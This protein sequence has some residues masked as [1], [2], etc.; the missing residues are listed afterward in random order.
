MLPSIIRRVPV[1][2]GR[3]HMRTIDGPANRDKAPVVERV[4]RGQVKHM[5]PEV[6]EEWKRKSINNILDVETA[7]AKSPGKGK[8]ATPTQK[9]SILKL[10]D[11]RPAAAVGPSSEAGPS[12][13][14]AVT[15]GSPKKGKKQKKSPTTPEGMTPSKRD[16]KVAA[17]LA[18]SPWA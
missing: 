8:A 18:F 9:D 2:N 6:L 15:A 7:G 13:A 3:S 17:F 5:D 16:G 11:K 1:K 10:F 12:S 14:G 4:T